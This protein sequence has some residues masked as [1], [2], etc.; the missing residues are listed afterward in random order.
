[1]FLILDSWFLVPGSC[2]CLAFLESKGKT[3][4]PASWRREPILPTNPTCNYHR[5]SEYM[6]PACLGSCTCTV[7]WPSF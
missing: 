2:G 4:V 7:V 5:S 6:Y 1:M 3:A